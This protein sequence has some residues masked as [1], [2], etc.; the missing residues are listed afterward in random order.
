MRT[1]VGLSFFT[2]FLTLGA[3]TLILMLP[4]CEVDYYDPEANSETGN[5]LFGDSVTVPAGFDWGTMRAINVSVK[6]DDRYNGNYFYIVELFDSNPVIDANANLLSKGVAKAN[7]DYKTS[8]VLTASLETIYIQ[9]TN[10]T[11]GKTIAPVNI[12]SS[13][14]DYI[15]TTV[16]ATTRFSTEETENEMAVNYSFRA[17]TD[18]YSLPSLPANHT[19]ITQ[20]SGNLSRNLNDGT[21]LINGNFSGTTS[22]WGKGDIFVSGTLNVISGQLQVPDGSRLIILPGGSVTT[23]DVNSWGI[24]EV[25][26]AGTLGVNNQ[27]GVPTD[28]KCIVLQGGTLNCNTLDIK[29]VFYNNG[30][31]NVSDLI[32]T[33]NSKADLVNDNVILTKRLE[34]ATE[35]AKM[36]N[37]GTID[38]AEEMKVSNKNGKVSNA[39]SITAQS[40][41]FD[42]GTMEN[43][44]V[45][46]IKG[47]TKATNSNVLLTNNNSFTTNTMLVS[48]SATVKNNCH[49]TVS[50]KLELEDAKIIINQGGLLSTSYLTM[51]NTR[52]ELG[53]AAM[54]DVTTLATYKYNNRTNNHGFYGTGTNKA[55]L[56]I[57]K[58]VYDK[59]NDENIIHYQGNFEIECYD[60]VAEVLENKRT[61]WTQSGITWAGVGGSTLVIPATECNNGGNNNTPPS[62]PPTSPV[63]PIIYEGSTVTYLFEDGWPYL[64]DFD[65]NDLVMDL[66]PTYSMDGNNKVTQLR[67]DIEL[68]AIGATKRL[69]VG[70]QLDGVSPSAITN[71]TRTN[72]TGIN[73]SI[74]SLLTNGLEQGQTYAVIPLFDVVHEALGRTSSVMTNTIKGS[75]NSVSSLS[76]PFTIIFNTPIDKASVGLEK[77]NVFLVNGG[78]KTKRQEVHIAGFQATDKA[79]HSKFGFADDNSTV[80]P[81]TSK[82]NL[83][84][85]LAI[86]GS[87]KYPVEW[88]SIKVAYPE[89]E[90]WATSSG[91]TNME[92]Y[93]NPNLNAI[94]E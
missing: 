90:T 42:N 47:H 67:L 21:I 18:K 22:F 41:T 39:N 19:V 77:L 52:V 35:G 57:K 91:A 16:G 20:T 86:P 87:A 14:V 88:T 85:G 55:L 37:N 45:I 81:Y 30:H 92:W 32:K 71:V 84:W 64:G 72:S 89:F 3:I 48:S 70:L 82:G 7:M 75:P 50:D 29:S 56:R 26:V 53:S 9:Q 59:K 43:D 66:T 13:S 8:V 54:M 40:L 24:V 12:T 11:G 38:V 33:N 78:Y 73:G 58:T 10:P 4:G 65:M 25:F 44:G 76:V 1:K 79:D 46:L 2:L 36:T 49:L 83:I 28:S 17:V 6:V 51:N 60:H 69:G 23:P 27:F 15:F 62:T 31:I 63:F 93:K 34:I 74:F 61:R 68:R 5:L 94:Y 80:R